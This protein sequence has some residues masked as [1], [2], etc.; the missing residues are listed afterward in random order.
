MG[1]RTLLVPHRKGHIMEPVNTL[2]A[3]DNESKSSDQKIKSQ[4]DRVT[5]NKDES[6]KINTW[7]RQIKESSKGFLDLTRS[8]LVNY[9]IKAHLDVLT[10][11]EIKKIRLAH[12]S[13]IKHLN[14][15]TPQLKKAL[16]DNN[17]ELVF[18]LQSEL[19]SLEMGVIKNAESVTSATDSISNVI[20][21]SGLNT[22]RKQRVKKDKNPSVV[23][24]NEATEP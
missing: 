22:T 15:I 19:R 20:E 24:K 23:D 16:E 13:L 5:L 2:E 14:W 7:L 9:L 1:R 11:K 17:H 8:D 3:K 12:Y 4:V 10:A 18:S 21:N 6:E